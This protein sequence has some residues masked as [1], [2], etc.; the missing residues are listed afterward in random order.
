[1]SKRTLG[2]IGALIGVIYLKPLRRFFHDLLVA[3]KSSDLSIGRQMR[4][5][6]RTID[7]CGSTHVRLGHNTAYNGLIDTGRRSVNGFLAD[8]LANGSQSMRDEA[9]KRLNAMSAA[10]RVLID[11]R[12]LAILDK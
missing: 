4:S 9:T 1:M 2:I 7:K 6:G 11:P 5:W 10:D 3:Y 8:V 12:I